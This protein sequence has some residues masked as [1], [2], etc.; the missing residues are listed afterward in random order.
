[1]RK[2]LSKFYLFGVF[3]AFVAID[4]LIKIWVTH[5]PAL[6]IIIWQN[7]FGVDFYIQHITNRGGA[8]GLFASFYKPLLIARILVIIALLGY[9]FKENHPFK[10]C[11]LLTLI[12]AGASA[13]VLD[14]LIF[15]HVTDMFHFTFWGKSYGIF[16][17]ADTLIFLGAIGLLFLPKA[18]LADT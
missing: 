8:W 14:S 4:L 15:G 16:N 13:N 9:L 2:E 7:F 1:L 10:K 12:L 3:V 17:F 18:K 5:H 11:F 6:P